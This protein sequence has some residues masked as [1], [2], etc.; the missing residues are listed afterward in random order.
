MT[1]IPLKPRGRAAPPGLVEGF[2]LDDDLIPIKAKVI[3]AEPAAADEAAPPQSKRQAKASRAYAM[4][5]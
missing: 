5:K 2:G 4:G 1:Q 3:G